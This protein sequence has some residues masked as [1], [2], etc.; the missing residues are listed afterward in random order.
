[1][2]SFLL[3]FLFSFVA[4]IETAAYAIYEIKINKNKLAG[5]ILIV[6]SIIGFVFPIAVYLNT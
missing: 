2:S 3:A 6:L 5:I 1:M 4:C